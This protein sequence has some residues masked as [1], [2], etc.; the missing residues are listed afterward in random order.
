[1]Y[2]DLAVRLNLVINQNNNFC[3][4]HTLFNIQYI[5]LQV[6]C[7][8]VA[9][10]VISSDFGRGHLLSI[11]AMR[12]LTLE[13][14]NSQSTMGCHIFSESYD[15]ELSYGWCWLCMVTHLLSFASFFL[16]H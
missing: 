4:T 6:V 15:Q 11:L 5:L 13:H 3:E 16:Q 14:M 2:K 10:L 8:N 7:V 9:I 12:R 1:M